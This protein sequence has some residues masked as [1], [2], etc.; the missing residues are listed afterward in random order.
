M[1]KWI[2]TVIHYFPIIG[3]IDAAI[4]QKQCALLS[5]VQLYSFYL[6]AIPE[7][8]LGKQQSGFTFRELSAI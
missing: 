2:S 4:S 1:E 3:A 8:D 6:G 5:P 7:G